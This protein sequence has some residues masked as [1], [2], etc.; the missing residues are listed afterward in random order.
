MKIE[1]NSNEIIA[2]DDFELGWRWVNLHNAGILT[3][4]K[5]QL[6]P[7][8]IT[9]SKS[10]YKIVNFFESESNLSN[11]FQPNSWIRASSKTKES[12]DKFS[13][14]RAAKFEESCSYSNLDIFN[15]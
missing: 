5:I 4:N 12:I 7:L 1:L 3:E 14:G 10:L 2:L 11:G 6:K 9:E 8:R 15:R 13:E